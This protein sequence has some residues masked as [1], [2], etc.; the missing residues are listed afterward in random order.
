ML[1]TKYYLGDQIKKDQMGREYDTYGTERNASKIFMGKA[2]KKRLLGIP[3]CRWENNIK[4][5]LE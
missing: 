4:A 1:L 3:R 2:K 5:A